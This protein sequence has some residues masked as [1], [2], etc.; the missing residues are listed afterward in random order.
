MTYHLLPLV[1]EPDREPEVQRI[2]SDCIPALIHTAQRS[3][4]VSIA[5][6]VEQT[7][8]PI[9]A[10]STEIEPEGVMLAMLGLLRYGGAYVLPAIDRE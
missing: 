1:G 2:F 8:H 9:C 3:R 5:T 7:I 6:L 10:Y 4:H